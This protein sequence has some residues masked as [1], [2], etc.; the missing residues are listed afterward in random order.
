MMKMQHPPSRKLEECFN[1][2]LQIDYLH[3]ESASSTAVAEDSPQR[4]I[5]ETHNQLSRRRRKNVIVIAVVISR[6]R[7]RRRRRGHRRRVFSSP[8]IVGVYS[9]YVS[10]WDYII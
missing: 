4:I 2:Q 6:L 7:R 5:V 3:R 1:S 9:N 8:Y 10:A